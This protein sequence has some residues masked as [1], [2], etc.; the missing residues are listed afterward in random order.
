MSTALRDALNADNSFTSSGLTATV[1]SE[2]FLTIKGTNATSQTITKAGSSSS[3][4]TITKGG[5]LASLNTREA[6]EK[7]FDAIADAIINNTISSGNLNTFG[8]SSTS[9][10][11]IASKLI[12]ILTPTAQAIFGLD[13]TLHRFGAE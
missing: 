9:P 10:S 6:S 8:A 7:V 5:N 4:G 11:D 2:G 3:S 12:S 1:N 13:N